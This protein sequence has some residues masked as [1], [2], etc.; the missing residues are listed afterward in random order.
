MSDN[1]YTK[2]ELSEREA[3]QQCFSECFASR[4]EF[5]TQGMVNGRKN[6][7]LCGRYIVERLL[8]NLNINVE[9]IPVAPNGEPVWP[10]GVYGSISHDGTLIGAIVSNA[11]NLINI[12]LDI[13]KE[14]STAHVEKITKHIDADLSALY[15]RLP[16]K[17]LKLSKTELVNLLICAKETVIKVLS[18]VFSITSFHPIAIEDITMSEGV[19]SCCWTVKAN[20][21]DAVEV[22]VKTQKYGSYYIGVATLENE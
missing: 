16:V 17:K 22:S 15:L 7:F 8:S 12:G 13:H 2:F 5:E 11:P 14:I 21:N 3:V 19:E 18:K 6:E 20:Y 9:K 4:Y 10:K 1:G